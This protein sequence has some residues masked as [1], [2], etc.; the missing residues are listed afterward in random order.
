MAD[1]LTLPK[2]KELAK[3]YLDNEM[4]KLRTEQGSLGKLFGSSASIPNNIAAL[5]IL[6]LLISG[7]VYTFLVINKKPADIGLSIKDFWLII[8]P[9]I[10]LAIGYLFGDK[11]SK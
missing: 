6:I 7:I 9:L 1:Q 5:T 4:T 3:L 11:S 10:T 2:D 8:S